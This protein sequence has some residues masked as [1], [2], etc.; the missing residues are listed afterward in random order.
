MSEKKFDILKNAKDDI[1]EE[2]IPFSSDDEQTKKRVFEMSERKFNNMIKADKNIDSADS[3]ISVSGV[4]KYRRPVWYKPL[5]AAAAFVV[6]AGGVGT[7]GFMNRGILARKGPAAKVEEEMTT[8][9]ILVTEAVTEAVTEPLTEIATEAVTEGIELIASDSEGVPTEE[10]MKEIFNNYLPVY[11]DIYNLNTADT[12]DPT[13]E[14]ISFWQYGGDDPD[15]SFDQSLWPNSKK[16]GTVIYDH[17]TYYKVSDDRYSNLEEFRNYYDKYF[18]Y[19]R[20]DVNI[21]GRY[22]YCDDFSD[23]NVDDKITD[24]D[25]PVRRFDV[26]GYNGALY[27]PVKD[28]LAHHPENWDN[29][30]SDRSFNVTENSFVWERIN[31][32]ETETDPY[33]E[34][35][36]LEFVKCSDGKWRIS[37]H[38]LIYMAYDPS[39][40]YS[41]AEKSLIDGFTRYGESA[42]EAE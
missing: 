2:L 20:E 8:D 40:D 16:E 1:I 39:K 18:A 25:S 13:A 12:I 23:H 15:G 4:E 38:S 14:T 5:C 41:K 31:K 28:D 29:I 37:D 33:M 21:N 36:D 42:E 9:N 24:P 11:M 7:L 35:L 10:E 32:I 6:V 19:N 27:V 30:I 26:I 34:C 22:V 17:V 3:E